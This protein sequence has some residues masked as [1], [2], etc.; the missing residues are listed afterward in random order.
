MPNECELGILCIKQ[1]R[2]D[3]APDCIIYAK[4]WIFRI[5]DFDMNIR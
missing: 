5:H 4:L 2:I 3:Y 1:H